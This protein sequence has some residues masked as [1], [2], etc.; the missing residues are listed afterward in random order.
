MLGAQENRADEI[1]YEWELHTG[2]L[3]E[4]TD[5]AVYELLTAEEYA[6]PTVLPDGGY[7][8]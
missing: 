3:V 8:D 6:F 5:V 2:E 4:S 1:N 7:L